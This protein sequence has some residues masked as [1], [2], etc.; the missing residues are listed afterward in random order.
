MWLVMTFEK[1]ASLGHISP[2]CKPFPPVF[3]VLRDG[4]EL[5]KIKCNNSCFLHY[6]IFILRAKVRLFFDMTAII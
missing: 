1:G 6:L 2:F 3:I 5:R 4:M